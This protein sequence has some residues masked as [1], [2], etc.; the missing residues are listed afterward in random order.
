MNIFTFCKFS[1]ILCYSLNYN[2]FYLDWS[3]LFSVY[4]HKFVIFFLFVSQEYTFILK[5]NLFFYFLIQ[6]HT[7]VPYSK[8]KVLKLLFVV[9]LFHSLFPM[10]FFFSPHCMAC[11]HNISFTIIWTLRAF[12]FI[13]LFFLKIFVSFFVFSFNFAYILIC[14]L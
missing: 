2:I 13:F 4:G 5:V 12:Y 14:S 7:D 6:D 10:Y 9:S 8:Q 3:L 11:K 1:K